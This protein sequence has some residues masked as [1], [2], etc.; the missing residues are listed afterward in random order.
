M[1]MPIVILIDE[2]KLI[3]QALEA[4]K[5]KIDEIR[6]NKAV[7]PNLITTLVDFF[8]TYADRFH[9]GKEEGILFSEL[10]K[11]QLIETDKKAM[12]ELIE[13]HVFARHTVTAL[14]SA[15]E[16]YVAGKTQSADA[17]AELLQTLTE[18]YPRHIE[19]EDKHFFYPS[20]EYFSLKEREEMKAAFQL[21]NEGFTNKRYSQ[22]IE[23]LKK[24]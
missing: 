3:L 24:Q 22:V 6:S 4:I 18:F 12:N 1:S 21:F 8:R 15:K 2:H 14:E 11:K 23:A 17:V 19:K 13:E 5:T 20:M 10:T 7:D 16:N 9:H